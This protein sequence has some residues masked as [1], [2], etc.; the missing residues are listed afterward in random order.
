MDSLLAPRA[1]V[2]SVRSRSA[3]S[4]SLRSLA[5]RSSLRSESTGLHSVR[6]PITSR[7]FF[8]GI[9][10][11]SA[12]VRP[13]TALRC[14]LEPMRPPRS[15]QNLRSVILSTGTE[16]GVGKHSRER[17]CFTALSHLPHL[18]ALTCRLPSRCAPGPLKGP[19]IGALSQLRARENSAPFRHLL[20][21]FSAPPRAPAILLYS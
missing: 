6:L 8:N 14:S 21:T 5:N 9:A 1:P 19:L 18:R 2:R 20:G 17:A 10:C 3:H 4:L 7:F 12:S 16:G 15:S 13:E 11:S